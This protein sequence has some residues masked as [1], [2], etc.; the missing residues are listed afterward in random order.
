MAR[1]SS[2]QFVERPVALEHLREAWPI[3]APDERLEGL[4]LLTRERGEEFFVSLSGHDVADLIE[5]FTSAERRSWLRVLP[6]DDI[7]DMLQEVEEAE[8]VDEVLSLLDP[9]TKNEVRALLAY[10][11]DD[12]GGLMSPRFAMVRPEM[13]IDEAISY[14]RRQARNLETIYYM[15]FG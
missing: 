3:L 8:L 13:R 9:G 5:R 6:P 1:E 10:A 14:L 15:T 11:E 12:A 2:K 4:R 7:A